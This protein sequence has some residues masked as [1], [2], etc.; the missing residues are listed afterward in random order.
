[1]TKQTGIEKMA[2]LTGE[3]TDLAFAEQA[4]GLQVLLAEM[5]ALSTLLP[6][7]APDPARDPEQI[8]SDFDNMPI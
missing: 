5:Q 2:A 4:I 7:A 3:M 1:M 6:G 8:E